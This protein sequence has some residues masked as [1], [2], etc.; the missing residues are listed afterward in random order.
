MYPYFVQVLFLFNIHPPTTLFSRTQNR[1]APEMGPC[2]LFPL[3]FN[4]S[5]RSNSRSCS[6]AISRDDHNGALGLPGNHRPLNIY[7][8]V[9]R[10]KYITMHECGYMLEIQE[11]Q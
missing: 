9:D 2:H 3:P 10:K 11:N 8:S 1:Q 6:A 7:S 5:T 4:R